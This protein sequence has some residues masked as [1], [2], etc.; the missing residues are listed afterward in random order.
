ME[1]QKTTGWTRI[2]LHFSGWTFVLVSFPI[3]GTQS[4]PNAHH[5]KEERFDLAHNF[6][7]FRPWSADSKT[8]TSW[9]KGL[10]EQR[11]L[12]HGY[13]EAEQGKNTR[14]ERMRDQI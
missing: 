7:G 8:E 1:S 9:Q 10:V 4:I 5:C 6:T 2:I 14:E 3:T 12:V 11:C 13:Q